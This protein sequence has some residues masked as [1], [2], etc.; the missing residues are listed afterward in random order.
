M[1]RVN[2]GK[3]Y[4]QAV[5]ELARE[6]GELERWQADLSKICGVGSEAKLMSLLENPKLPFDT[7][8]KLLEERIGKVEPLVFNLACLLL[9]RGRLKSIGNVSRQY[10]GLVNAYHG[11]EHAEVFTAVP[12]SDQ[13][14]ER[15]SSRLGEMLGHRVIVDLR[16]DPSIIGGVRARIGDTLIDGSIRYKL[17]CLQ[18]GLVRA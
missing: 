1:P 5:F 3:R 17:G 18:R 9:S 2:S 10:E 6:R 15:L 14:K 7:K 13:E 16:T 4:A 8:K 11:I 12:L